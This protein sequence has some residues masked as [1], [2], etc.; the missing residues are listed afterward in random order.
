MYWNTVIPRTVN[1]QDKNEIDIIVDTGIKLFFVECKT[2]VFDMKDLDKFRNVV[3]N[4]GGFGAKAILVS[5]FK[6]T[7]IV[8]EKCKDNHLSVFWFQDPKTKKM[9]KASQLVNLLD[10]EYQKINPI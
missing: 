9:N 2:Q 7:N 6:P 1:E 4:F 3:K 8:L 10:N 5:Y